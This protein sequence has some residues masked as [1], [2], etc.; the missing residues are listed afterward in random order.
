MRIVKQQVILNAAAATGAGNTVDISGFETVIL[1]VSTASSASLTIKAQVSAGKDNTITGSLDDAPAFGSAASATNAWDYAGLI[2]TNDNSVIAGSTGYAF[3][4]T[5][6]VVYLQLNNNGNRYL[7][8][9][10]TAR[11]A[12]SVSVKAIMFAN[13]SN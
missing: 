5:D 9:S 6:G 11:S 12:G 3:A 4:G 1:A 2:N 10:V 8:V 13:N 7:N